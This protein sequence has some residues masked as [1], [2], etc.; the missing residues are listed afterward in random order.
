MDKVVAHCLAHQFSTQESEVPPLK[1]PTHY[2][3][4]LLAMVM[5]DIC[6]NFLFLYCTWA[7]YMKTAEFGIVHLHSL[8]EISCKIG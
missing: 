1:T 8:H 2:V 7:S 5:M 4:S 3:I 6:I